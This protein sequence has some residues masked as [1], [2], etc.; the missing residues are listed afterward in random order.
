MDELIALSLLST[1]QTVS[2]LAARTASRAWSGHGRVGA[3]LGFHRP[4]CRHSDETARA[5]HLAHPEA[6]VCTLEAV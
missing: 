5:D 1:E 4:S 6:D 3:L 2:A